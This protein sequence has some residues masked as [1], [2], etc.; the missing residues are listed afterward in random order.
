MGDLVQP[1][2]V[3][4][5]A[6]EAV[7]HSPLGEFRDSEACEHVCNRPSVLTICKWRDCK[8]DLKG[9]TGPL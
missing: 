2:Q 3:E 5:R 8:D 1:R 7:M 4:Y 9:P 6:L